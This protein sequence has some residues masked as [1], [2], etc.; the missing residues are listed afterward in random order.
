MQTKILIYDLNFELYA[1][2]RVVAGYIDSWGG[3]L[4]VDACMFV[5]D[6]AIFSLLLL[7]QGLAAKT[8]IKMKK[9]KPTLE[10]FLYAP[11]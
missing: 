9:L 5:S 3:N 4:T 10:L 1:V 2:G 6:S 8:R 11:E 7:L